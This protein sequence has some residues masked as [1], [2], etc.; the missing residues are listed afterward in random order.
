MVPKPTKV[1]Q[2]QRYGRWVAGLV[3][4]GVLVYMSYMSMK[5]NLALETPV[6]LGMLALIVLLMFGVESLEKLIKTWR[7]GQ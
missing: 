2:I 4:S 7:G 3:A 5:M 6:I 1:E